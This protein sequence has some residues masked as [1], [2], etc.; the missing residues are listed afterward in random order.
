VALHGSLET[1]GL[2]EVLSLLS[3]TAKTGELRVNADRLTGRLWFAEGQLVGADAGRARSLVDAV[4]ELLRLDSGTFSFDQDRKAP[5]PSTPS[6]IGLV[7]G[8]AKDRLVEWRE[9][10]KVVPA[11]ACRVTLA[12]ELSQPAVTV[13]SD[14]WKLLVVFGPGGT[15]EDLVERYGQSE[16]E[17]CRAVRDL[18]DGGLVEV[19]PDPKA[20]V[21]DERRHRDGLSQLTEGA[22]VL[23]D[24][25][26][27]SEYTESDEASDNFDGT[28]LLGRIGGYFN[29]SDEADVNDA[30]VPNESSHLVD[31]SGDTSGEPD[32][33]AIV[34]TMTQPPGTSRFASHGDKAN[35]QEADTVTT[36]AD[37][38]EESADFDE[39]SDDDEINRGVLLKFLSSVRE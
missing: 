33:D 17:A 8:E 38:V 13:T 20:P 25:V 11:L 2:E 15:V 10:E 1:L 4:F 18:V 27:A 24:V 21:F 9:I 29:D 31:A 3:N 35:A 30:N 5:S 28:E 19:G 36:V 6:P 22:E 12:G 37:D 32:L 7:L 34:A 26:A 14:Q 23:D 39:A 16:F